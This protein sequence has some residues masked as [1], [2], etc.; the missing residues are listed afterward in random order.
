MSFSLG[1]VPPGR[2]EKKRRRR[3]KKEWWE[4]EDTWDDLEKLNEA[5]DALKPI[6]LKA[7]DDV[8]LDLKI[9]PEL[10]D[11]SLFEE[12]FPEVEMSHEVPSLTSYDVSV[13]PNPITLEDHKFLDEG[14]KVAEEVKKKVTPDVL[15]KAF[16]DLDISQKAKDFLLGKEDLSSIT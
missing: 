12:D 10:E 14:E 15:A 1:S 6:V 11:E 7:E 13:P 16:A 3:K 2:V 8:D 4:F 9:L 5:A